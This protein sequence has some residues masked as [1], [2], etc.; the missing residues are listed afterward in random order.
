MNTVSTGKIGE[1]IA[2]QYLQNHGYT[3]IDTHVTFHWGEIDIIAKRDTVLAFIEVKTRKSVM[4]GK[5]YEAFH[6]R[7]RLHLQ[8][9][10]EMYIKQHKLSRMKMAVDVVSISLISTEK[11]PKIVLYQNVSL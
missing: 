10:I 5:P 6:Y 1:K 9:S 3:I 8:R 4:M 2:I 11:D 7:K